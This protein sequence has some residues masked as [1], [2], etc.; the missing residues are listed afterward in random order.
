MRLNSEKKNKL[1][2]EGCIQDLNKEK[3]SNLIIQT[4]IIR[5]KYIMLKII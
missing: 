5:N 4:C 2:V 3:T 1:E